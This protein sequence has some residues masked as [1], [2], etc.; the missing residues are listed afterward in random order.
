M[1]LGATRHYYD[2]QIVAIN[3]DSSLP[4]AYATLK[5]A[6]TA[7]NN[8][9]KELGAFFHPMIFS[10]GGLMEEQTAKE[11]KSLQ[12]LIGRPLAS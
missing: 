12:E 2:V 1:L 4:N 11:Y 6:A 5:E 3:K 7:K 10:A 9:Y 8:K